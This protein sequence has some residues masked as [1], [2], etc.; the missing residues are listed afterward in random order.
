MRLA[1]YLCS[2]KG[3]HGHLWRGKHKLLKEVTP[4]DRSNLLLDYAR[5][6]QNMFYLRHPYLTSEQ[7]HGHA[8]A[9][10]K[11]VQWIENFRKI[12]TT[13]KDHFTMEMQYSHLKVKDAWE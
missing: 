13:Y 9:L 1:L 7:S 4:K 6:E 10:N 11:K 3:P 2:K 12:R 5:E 8:L